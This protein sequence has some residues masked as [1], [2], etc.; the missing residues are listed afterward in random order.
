[1]RTYDTLWRRTAP[2][3]PSVDYYTSENMRT[4]SPKT[5]QNL[6]C[7]DSGNHR[8]STEKGGIQAGGKVGG[9]GEEEGGELWRE[10][11]GE[12]QPPDPAEWMQ[13]APR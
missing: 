8:G 7:L 12:Q 4:E 9:Q 5:T 1:M 11:D 3:A 13:H 10:V 6:H 2:E